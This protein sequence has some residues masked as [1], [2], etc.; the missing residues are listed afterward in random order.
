[1]PPTDVFP[2]CIPDMKKSQTKKTFVP[3]FFS[4]SGEISVKTRRGYGQGPQAEVSFG[5]GRLFSRKPG[6]R[7]TT[8][9]EGVQ[10]QLERM[11]E[12]CKERNSLYKKQ[13]D[14]KGWKWEIEKSLERS[15][16]WG[17][18]VAISHISCSKLCRDMLY[19]EQQNENLSKQCRYILKRKECKELL[20][21]EQSYHNR[22]FKLHICF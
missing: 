8:A 14:L 21:N 13:N 9:R 7:E 6:G 12:R 15:D 17:V 5:H 16:V 4:N 19:L 11:K 20:A 3:G 2:Y 22:Y 18:T 10:A 1:M